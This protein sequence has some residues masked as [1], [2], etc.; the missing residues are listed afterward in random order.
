MD[1]RHDTTAVGFSA[2]PPDPSNDVTP[3]FSFSASEASSSFA[4]KLDEGPFRLLRLPIDLAHS[5]WD[6]NT[7]SV[8]VI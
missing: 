6:R 4:C 1:G 7:F 5:C 3:S 2:K 8:R